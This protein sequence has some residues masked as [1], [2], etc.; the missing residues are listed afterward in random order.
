MLEITHLTDSDNPIY[1]ISEQHASHLHYKLNERT[2]HH[3]SLI[4][5]PSKKPWQDKAE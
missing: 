1:D 5:C 2:Y 4:R 3:E